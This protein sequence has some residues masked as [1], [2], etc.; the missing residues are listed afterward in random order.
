MDEKTVQIRKGI[1]RILFVIGL[2]L[3]ILSLVADFLG[4][5][6]TPDFGMVQMLQLLLGLTCLTLAI[7]VYLTTARPADAPRSL[8]ADIC[9]RLIATGL[10][11]MYVSGFSD[12]IGIGT[13]IDPNFDRPFVGELQL[14]GI[15]LGIFSIV[16]GM[17]LYHTSR[18]IRQSSS[19]EFLINGNGQ[20]ESAS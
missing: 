18:G 17:Y 2:I 14:L 3:S 16:M 6:L 13:H 7:F 8:Q 12:L 19:L 9:V 1:S 5:D 20:E 10:V 15:G 4:L 11:F